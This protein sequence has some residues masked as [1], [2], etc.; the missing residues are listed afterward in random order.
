MTSANAQLP[1]AYG[2]AFG[3][4]RAA[5]TGGIVLF[6]LY[7]VCWA[8]TAFNISYASHLYLALFSSGGGATSASIVAG[9]VSS[10]V[11][12]SFAGALIAATYN[13]LRFLGGR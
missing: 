5:L 9:L 4:L 8:G 2:G 7:L 10:V 1:V 6:V 12:G 13:S 3:V 11:F